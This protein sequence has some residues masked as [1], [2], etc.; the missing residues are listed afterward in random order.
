MAADRT[1]TDSIHQ[2]NEAH[3]LLVECAARRQ[4][5][6]ASGGSASAWRKTCAALV[7]STALVPSTHHAEEAIGCGAR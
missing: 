1:A 7:A 4:M 2:V 6:G 5:G 3:V